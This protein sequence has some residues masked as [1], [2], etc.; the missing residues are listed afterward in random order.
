MRNIKIAYLFSCCFVILFT[1][2]L[3]FNKDLIKTAPVPLAKH[4]FN[5]MYYL[6]FYSPFKRD[7]D[8]SNLVSKRLKSYQI[9]QLSLGFNVPIVTK[10]FYNKDSTKISNIHF[11]LT[12][13]YSSINLNFAG[14]EKHRL[15]K[16][17]IGF[18]GLFNDGKKSL[19]FVEFSPFS[20]QDKG[21]RNTR[22]IRFAATVLYNCAVNDYF[23]FRVG[24]TRSYLW[25]N[26]FHLPYI[27]IRVGK[28]DKVNFSI[29]FPRSITFNAPIGKYI[30]T[31]LYTKPQGGLYTFAN[32]DSIKLGSV[33]ENDILYF[34][35][36]EFLAGARIDILPTKHF[37][38]YL[39][40]GFTTQNSITFYPKNKS[41]STFNS[42]DNFYKEKI[43]SSMFFNFGLVFRFGKTKSIYNNSQMYNGLDVNNTIDGGDNGINPGNGNIPI[44]PKKIKKNKTDDVLDLIET[45]D[46]Y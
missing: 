38:F 19:F 25:G 45:Q 13:N 28:L 18:R 17:A 10:D 9:S 3:A 31:S 4:Y 11:L 30:R 6:D 23:S 44:V 20:T 33:Y 21:Y 37:N 26:Q 15:T 34:G 32:T 16:T 22:I 5:H 35:R 36:Y 7:L 8:T 29:Q 41:R 2:L 1:K 24:F 27:G 40:S 43:G 42:Y 39:S 46:L 12:G 14:I